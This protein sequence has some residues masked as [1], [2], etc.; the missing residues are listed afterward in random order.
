MTR[1]LIHAAV[2]PLCHLA[3]FRSRVALCNLEAALGTRSSLLI[4]LAMGALARC[5]GGRLAPALAQAMAAD[6]PVV[7]HMADGAVEF[8]HALDVE[9]GREADIG[10]DDV[11]EDADLPDVM[12]VL[13]PTLGPCREQHAETLRALQKG[14]V[15]FDTRMPT[16]GER[17]LLALI[18]K[19]TTP[20]G[21]RQGVMPDGDRWL[22]P[23][24]D[25]GAAMPMALVQIANAPGAVCFVEHLSDRV[26]AMVREYL[27][28]DVL[29]LGVVYM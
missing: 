15:L 4:T 24:D 2:Q 22:V 25:A 13:I 27:E 28:P 6:L 16:E 8:S 11:L 14:S 12:E 9:E 21:I 20:A 7:P 1:I 5:H 10:D 23:V 3:L 17:L 29:P 18:S 19:G 26:M